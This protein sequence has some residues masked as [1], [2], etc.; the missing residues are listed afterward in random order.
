VLLF[1]HECRCGIRKHQPVR[2]DG[3]HDRL[4]SGKLSTKDKAATHVNRGIL[5]MALE[6]YGS[7][8]GD[9]D[10][11]AELH[12]DYGAIYLN[13]GNIFFIQ[14]SYDR[15]IAE[16]TKALAAEMDEPQV[17]YLNRGMAY[18]TL[19]HWEAAAADYRG[20]LELDPQWGVAI[21][22]LAGV[23]AKLN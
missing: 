20:A 7:A 2:A 18:E 9:F 21:S 12:P 16:Y 6:E 11:A 23:S 4:E 15:A 3:L 8:L 19:A 10:A 13:R 1:R 22:K 17:A 14:E 5:S